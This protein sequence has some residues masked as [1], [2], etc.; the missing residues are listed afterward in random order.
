M[1]VILTPTSPI[2]PPTLEAI[3]GPDART[4]ELKM[5]RNTRPVQCIRLADHLHFHAAPW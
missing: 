5:L 2:L 3:V 1:D 4:L